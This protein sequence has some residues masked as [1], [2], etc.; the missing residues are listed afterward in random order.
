MRILLVLITMLIFLDSSAQRTDTFDVYFER[1]DAAV[2]AAAR[3]TINSLLSA[4][5]IKPG[6]RLMLR[7]YADY[8]GSAGHNDSLSLKRAENVR[9]TL[10]SK[11]FREED[12]SLCVGKG[13]V[14]REPAG[15]TGYRA[16]RKVQ[17]VTGVTEQPKA[18]RFKM[19]IEMVKVHGK[20]MNYAI[21]KYHITQAQWVAVMGNNPAEFKGCDSCPIERVSIHK[22][23]EFLKK[24]DSLT[25]IEYRLPTNAEWTYAASGGSK[26][27]NYLFAGSKD[28]N[29]VA[30]YAGNSDSRTHPVG[31]KKPNE[32]GLYDMSG[33]V[34]QWCKES[35]DTAKRQLAIRGG[36]YFLWPRYCSYKNLCVELPVEGNGA[37][38]FRVAYSL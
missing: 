2:N 38:G 14:S 24:L 35:S 34:W 12:I 1:N 37:V 10:L 6:Q 11:G 29:E 26:G 32:L 21:G 30:W 16:D 22:I 31:Q 25:G 23:Y 3:A 36:A 17:I 5:S 8:L 28:I 9:R 20:G 4:N 33:N 15:T 13:S 19:E 18:S 7:G 27:H